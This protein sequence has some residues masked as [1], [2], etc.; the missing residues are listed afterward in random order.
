MKVVVTGAGGFIGRHLV[1]V[2]L[3]R[4]QL[5]G[6]DGR[7]A[8]IRRLVLADV[9][10]PT[11]RPVAGID[12]ETVAGDMRDPAFAAGLT[13][14]ADSIF[15]LA[16]TLT[17]ATEA[18]PRL[19]IELNVLALVDLLERCR[20]AGTAPKLV[21]VSSMAT[22]G[23]AL[24][25][26]VG[27]DVFQ[28][29]QTSYGAHKVIAERLIDDYSRRGFLDGRSLRF[30]FVLIRRS[31]VGAVS[32]RIAQILRDPLAGH[33]VV[34]PVA[35]ETRMAVVSV[36]RSAAAL[37]D[38]HDVPAGSFGHTRAINMPSLTVTAAEMI[39]AMKRAGAG[40]RLGAVTFAPDP[41]I[42][43]IVD[44]WPAVF[45]SQRAEALGLRPDDSFEAICRA[46]LD[47]VGAR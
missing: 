40:R 9:A 2:L 16:A 10:A 8:P 31:G 32:D 15:H 34:A 41:E 23:G 47:E 6:R 28:T 30:P 20:I 29:P 19:G 33:D 17:T 25:A 5:V 46:Y 36:Q 13:D 38:L 42:Q 4:K 22:F 24:P 21:F 11:V 37:V 44:G 3:A 39:D 1:T 18:N 26:A 27:D 12:V 14:G 35:P 7:P 45:G 43:R